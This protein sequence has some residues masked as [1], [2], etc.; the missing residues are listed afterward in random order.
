MHGGGRVFVARKDLKEKKLT[1]NRQVNMTVNPRVNSYADS[2]WWSH[3]LWLEVIQRMPRRA[4]IGCYFCQR[5]TIC[6]KICYK[7][8]TPKSGLSN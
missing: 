8:G 2:Q 7:S 4:K 3:S 1:E 5:G 6:C